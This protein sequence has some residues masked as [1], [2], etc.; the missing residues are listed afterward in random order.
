MG[1]LCAAWYRTI[2]NAS[3]CPSHLSQGE[4]A[5]AGLQEKPGSFNMP[6]LFLMSRHEAQNKRET[7]SLDHSDHTII[8]EYQLF[9][10]FLCV[11]SS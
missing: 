10:L 5:K 3:D 8:S 9:A 4:L 11:S 7:P 2:M 1:H 6:F